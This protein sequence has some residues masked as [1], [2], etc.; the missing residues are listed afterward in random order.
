MS[1]RMPLDLELPKEVPIRPQDIPRYT[2]TAGQL[3]KQGQFAEVVSLC[4]RLLAL[5]SNNTDARAHLAA[6]YK[7]LGNE[8]LFRQEQATL[9]KQAPES[10]TLYLSMAATYTFL[11]EFTAAEA[12]YMKGLEA[13]LDKTKLHM[14][15]GALYLK[16]QRLRE[17]SEQYLKVLT[18][19]G[20]DDK[21]FL[22]ANFALCRIG[23]QEKRY[24]D[25]IRR[26]RTVTKLYPPVPQGHLLLGTAYRKKG[27]PRQALK[28]Y[29]RLMEINPQIPDAYLELALTNLEISAN[30]K[31]ALYFAMHA[32]EKFPQDARSKDVLGWVYYEQARYP[33]AVVQFQKAVQLS[34]DNPTFL[35]HLGL[36]F[37][38]TGNHDQAAETFQQALELMNSHKAGAF[39]DELQRRIEQSRKVK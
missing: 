22:N 39:V 26:A 28:V 27:T 11:K 33:E 12:T 29:Q 7:G 9:I 13:T 14:G 6:A 34:K 4:K 16:Q 38:K 20:L 25:V 35:Y 5:G 2:W 30:T 3:L 31:K 32:V 15:L 24:D 8:K 17:S 37:Q 36:G 10:S 23:L 18:Q 21:Q 19:K 1:D